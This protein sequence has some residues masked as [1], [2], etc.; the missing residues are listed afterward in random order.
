MTFISAHN[1]SKCQIS[2]ARRDVPGVMK[3]LLE[4][5]SLKVPVES[6]GTVAGVQSWRQRV[7]SFRRCDREATRAECCVCEQN[8]EQIGTGGLRERAGV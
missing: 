1:A 6:V 2:G 4:V 8:G 7:P 3:R 5:M